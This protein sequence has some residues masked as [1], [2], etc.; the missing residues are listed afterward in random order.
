MDLGLDMG[1]RSGSGYIW[2]EGVGG[3]GLAGWM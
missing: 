2:E 1:G 3:I